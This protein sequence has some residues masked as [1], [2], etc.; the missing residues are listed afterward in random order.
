[1]DSVQNHHTVED[2]V[3]L[4]KVL[5][6]AELLVRVNA[7]HEVSDEHGSSED[8]IEA[9]VAAGADIVMLPYF[10]TVGEIERF[11]K[12]VDGRTRT[13]LLLETPEAVEKLD[14]IL[15]IKG[16]DE[17]HIGIND[18]SI[19]MGKKFM[20]IVKQLITCM[21]ND[22]KRGYGAKVGHY[23]QDN[24]LFDDQLAA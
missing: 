19:G 1:M 2:V 3:R 17:I 14:D 23:W 7:I 5:S 8:E 24:P 6:K 15:K 13:M 12:A 11:L 21:F 16:I 10:K 4:R 18:L 22:Q 9:V 20:F